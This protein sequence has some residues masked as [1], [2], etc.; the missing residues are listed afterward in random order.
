MGR[1]A[2]RK[3]LAYRVMMRPT[4]VPLSTRTFLGAPPT[5][6]PGARSNDAKPGRKKCAAGTRWAVWH[7]ERD[8]SPDWAKRNPGQM[9]AAFRCA[10]CCEAASC[11]EP[12]F[13]CG[14]LR[15]IVSGLLF[16]M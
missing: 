15:S 12:T 8:R 10:Q 13:T 9:A 7:G 16:T 6:F 11:E 1:K 5:L 14:R 2:P 3:R 4:G